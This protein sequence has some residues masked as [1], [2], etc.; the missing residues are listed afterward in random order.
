[1]IREPVNLRLIFPREIQEAPLIALQKLDEEEL[2]EL[3]KEQREEEKKQHRR[4]KPP[5]RCGFCRH[6]IT[7]P[8]Q[9]VDV[10]GQ[11]RHV[12]TNPYGIRYEIGCFA[13]AGGCAAHGPPTLEY[14][15]FAGYTWRVAL[16]ANC[17]NHLGWHY[18]GADGSFY[19]LI[20]VNLL[21]E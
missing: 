19:G 8:E 6:K 15:W 14:T 2:E 17:H 20:L 1:M 3:L 13:Q 7:T 4:Q 9:R 18:R 16:C 5:I 21:E 10:H 11:H 12:F